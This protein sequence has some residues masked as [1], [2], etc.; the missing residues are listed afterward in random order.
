MNEGWHMELW[1]RCVGR[2]AG[3]QRKLY[4]GVGLGGPCGCAL[5]AGAPVEQLSDFEDLSA[6]SL[7]QSTWGKLDLVL[8]NS[9]FWSIVAGCFLRL[10]Q[11]SWVFSTLFLNTSLPA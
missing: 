11:A 1:L 4:A 6:T 7:I 2:V 3:A 8:S 5:V 9:F 10:I